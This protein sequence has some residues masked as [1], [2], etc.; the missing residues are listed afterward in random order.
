MGL[1]PAYDSFSLIKAMEKERLICFIRAAF[2]IVIL[3]LVKDHQYFWILMVVVLL[4]QVREIIKFFKLDDGHLPVE[5]HEDEADTDDTSLNW[6]NTIISTMWTACL[7]EFLTVEGVA[8]LLEEGANVCQ[9]KHR[10][11]QSWTSLFF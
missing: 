6:I 8:K 10:H 11:K 1:R 3:S 5:Y 4:G 9:E 7:S 2:E